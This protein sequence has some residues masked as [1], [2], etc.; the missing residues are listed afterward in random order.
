MSTTIPIICPHCKKVSKGPSELMG[1]KIRCK[2]CREIFTVE[3]I[4][5]ASPKAPSRKPT[6][7]Q[8][9]KEE[10]PVLSIAEEEE[11]EGEARPYAVTD[12]DLTPRCPHCANEM[13]EGA[14]ICVHCGYNTQ[15]RERFQTRKVI[16]NTGMDIFVWLL[17]GILCV[18]VVLLCIAG[19]VYAWVKFDDHYAAN[20]EEWWVGMV[21]G[22]FAKIYSSVIELF[23]LYFAAMFAI[24]RLILHPTPPEKI[25]H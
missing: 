21:F 6:K 8:Q 16:E 20:K 15:T 24:K 23:I 18:I 25:V 9:E 13:E 1:K 10:A 12:I 4:K 14:I 2:N 22:M 5:Q 19:I 7:P 11:D 3:R 17:P